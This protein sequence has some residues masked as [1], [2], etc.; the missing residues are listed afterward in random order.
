M[1]EGTLAGELRPGESVLVEAATRSGG[2]RAVCHDLLATATP[3]ETRALVVTMLDRAPARQSQ[4]ETH[5]DAGVPAA[6][7]VVEVAPGAGGDADP[8]AD[9]GWNAAVRRVASPSDLTEI[10]MAVG[11]VLD[12]WADADGPATVCFHSVSALLQ[13]AESRRVFRFLHLLTSRLATTGARSHFHFDPGMHDDQ[14]TATVRAV[15]DGVVR[16]DDDGTWRLDRD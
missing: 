5:V 9:P 14:E 13:Y 10:G 7:A 11:S 16:R 3:T 2:E 12:S 15:F 6:L 8:P 4:W 1:T